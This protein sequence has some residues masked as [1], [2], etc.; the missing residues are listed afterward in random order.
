MMWLLDG[1]NELFGSDALPLRILRNA[2]L[3]LTNA[4]GPVKRRI[5]RRAMGIEGRFTA[6]RPDG[7][8]VRAPRVQRLA[9]G[10]W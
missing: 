10:G 8:L 1:F 3:T 5:I 4:V 9:S 2:G 7:A 6:A